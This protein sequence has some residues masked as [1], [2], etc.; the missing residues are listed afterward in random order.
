M[1]TMLI[2]LVED[3]DAE[4]TRIRARLESEGEFFVDTTRTAEAALK[5]LAVMM[6]DA[7]L[8]D[9]TLPDLPAQEICRVMR[10]RSRTSAVPCIMLG[11]GRRGLRAIDGLS[12]GAD[13]YM[14]KPLDLEELEARLRAVLRRP[15]PRPLEDAPAAFRG[16][17]IDAN[18]ADVVVSVDGKRVSLTKREL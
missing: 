11:D 1:R 8:L 6:P 3:V 13:D 18:F 4:A 16:K 15:A 5:W 9:T 12:F 10:S 7:V 2:L 14:T 17:H